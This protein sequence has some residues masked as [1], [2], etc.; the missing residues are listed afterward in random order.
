MRLA[1][2]TLVLASLAAADVAGL[3]DKWTSNDLEQ[4]LQDQKHTLK[5]A[6]RENADVLRKH[7]QD[8]WNKQSQPTPWWKFWGSRTRLADF[9]TNQDPVS[10]WI[11]DTWS[12]KDLRKLLSK[13]K[14][15]YDSDL[16][17]DGLVTKAKENFDKISEKA[18]LSGLYPSQ[19]Y[20]AQWDDYDLQS[21]LD[22]YHVPYDKAKAKKDDLLA[23][24]REN[25]YSASRYV[26]DERLNLLEQLDLANQQV[27]DKAGKI[28]DDV[29]NSWSTREIEDWLRSHK[30][31]I[32]D[33]AA[34]DRK[35][36]L[37]LANK[38]KKYL[39]DDATWYLEAAKKKASP[40]FAKSEEAVASVWGQTLN[41]F[42]GLKDYLY[43]SDNIVN[44]TFLLGVESWP[45]KRLRSFLDARGVSYSIF[46]TRA[47]LLDLVKQYS[48]RPL[49]NLAS[50]P[51]VADIFDGWS[52]ENLKDWV[53]D[54]NDD[55][56]S[57]DIYQSASSKVGE[58]LAGTRSY[59][60]QKGNDA[61]GYA[62]KK[63]SDAAGYAQKK[64]SDA[65]EYAHQKGNDAAG[66]AQKKGS[67]AA[68]YAQKK[69]SE[70][71]GYAQEKGS[72][73]AEAASEYASEKGT[74]AASYAKSKG[75]DAASYAKD[76][77]SDAADYAKDKGSDAMGYAQQ[78]TGEA[79]AAV[80][81][82]GS[83]FYDAASDKVDDWT[84]LFSSW[85]TEDLKNYA[86]SFGI[87]TGPTTTREKLVEQV[88]ENT[89][90][91]F[92]YYQDPMYKRVPKKISNM[93][94]N[95]YQYVFKN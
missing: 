52:L 51:A 5:K 38:N 11:F 23:K 77:S 48:N 80:R 81:A 92:G 14:V 40:F 37:N 61:A 72:E 17:R 59:A 32:E 75:A 67:D 57:S 53:K 33:K 87:R 60:H 39:Q 78:K 15:K 31:K 63:G 34:H 65:A 4:Y 95:S 94:T 86:K 12:A 3:Y 90:W 43:Q 29:F 69:G 22:E 45:K 82:S 24:V 58:I 47:D 91:F 62:Q 50:S 76:K 74:D 93:M 66:Y 13:G 83:K 21:W 6:G 64:G 10:E 85:S 26:D 54:K 41:K 84:T 44:H 8:A 25:I 2:S 18:G 42:K 1:F 35:Y 20:F 71:A 73:A 46:S 27:A 28:K 19:Q 56:T 16:S 89:Q 55:I 9:A 70:A 49:T 68:G 79:A 7:A 36:V 30:V 88:K